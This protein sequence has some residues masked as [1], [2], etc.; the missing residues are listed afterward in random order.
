MPE[1]P[2]PF[3]DHCN[4]NVRWD[5]MPHVFIGCA[6]RGNLEAVRRSLLRGA[7][8]NC[9]SREKTPLI[10]AA[11][12]GHAETVELL[13]KSG[14]DL[15]SVTLAG[16]SAL[17]YAASNPETSS[18]IQRATVMKLMAYGADPRLKDS[19]GVAPEHYNIVDEVMDSDDL[20]EERL[21]V[22]EELLGIHREQFQPCENLKEI[23]GGRYTTMHLRSLALAGPFPAVEHV[24]LAHN[25][26]LLRTTEGRAALAQLLGSCQENLRILGL[27]ITRATPEVLWAVAAAGPFRALQ[28]VGLVGNKELLRTAEGG[29]ALAQL[30]GSCQESLRCI[31]LQGTGATP[32]A[33]QAVVAAGPFRALQKVNLGCNQEPSAEAASQ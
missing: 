11:W 2:C 21:R 17:L 8:V 10:V 7:D 4:Q 9:R 32:E 5:V 25:E 12:H 18:E 3:V 13:I 28:R 19:D 22:V 30:L 15:D 33:L 27:A 29:V 20:R 24:D 6:S 31:D 16:K 26:E 1:G 14:A 23:R